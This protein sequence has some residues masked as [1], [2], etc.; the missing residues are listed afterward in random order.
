[1]LTEKLAS[2][3]LVI[4][5]KIL[6][7]GIDSLYLRLCRIARPSYWLSSQVA[8]WRKY[9]A[10]EGEDVYLVEIPEIGTFKLLPFKDRPYEFLLTNR[11]IGNLSIWN[12]DKW[13]SAIEGQTGQFYLDVRSKFLQYEGIEGVRRLIKAIES[14]FCAQIVTEKQDGTPLKMSGW[15]RISRVDLFV[16]VQAPAMTWG[17][18]PKYVSRARKKEVNPDSSTE[19]Q[20]AQAL[21]KRLRS[22]LTASAPPHGGNK[23]GAKCSLTLEDLA[24]LDS[25]VAQDRGVEQD[26]YLY[27]CL[28]TN[29]PQSLYFGRFGS[30]LYGRQYDKL[31][32]LEIQNKQYMR[33]IWLNNGWDGT[34]PVRR[35]EFSLSGDFLR[36]V[37]VFEVQDAPL[38][39]RDFDRFLGVADEIWHY[40]T[41]DWLRLTV[42][43]PCDQTK[44]RWQTD[45]LWE[46]IQ[47][48]F[49]CNTWQMV[50]TPPQRSCPESHLVAQMRG[51]AL[52][53]AARRS[54][55]DE[56]LETGFSIVQDILS[57][58]DEDQYVEKLRKRRRVLGIDDFSDTIF[59]AYKRAQTLAEGFGS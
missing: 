10:G 40:L 44:S 24:L 54:Q 9:Q 58:V 13:Q 4:Q 57:F 49:S 43:D 33:E 28:F 32:S 45:P 47:S 51:L 55:S 53:I 41:H 22:E 14:V 50:R 46:V 39:Y 8:A 1:M 6:N 5:P 37:Q 18:L 52:S 3:N 11:E 56:E 59:S 42:P 36:Q 25:A 2:E 23:G 12:P 38:D 29:D 16:D 26:G 21:L 34:S 27:R 48:G 31:A 15:E 7:C 20:R 35:Q 17:E 30:A 19:T